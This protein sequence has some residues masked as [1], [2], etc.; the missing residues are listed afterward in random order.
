MFLLGDALRKKKSMA[1]MMMT[2]VMR[3][4]TAT[5]TNGTGHD[6]DHDH[7]DDNGLTGDSER[8]LL[9]E[10]EIRLHF[11]ALVYIPQVVAKIQKGAVQ[12]N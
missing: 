3:A 6:D 4:A 5:M 11:I 7:D 12:C 2:V 8:L 9:T 10:K 1:V